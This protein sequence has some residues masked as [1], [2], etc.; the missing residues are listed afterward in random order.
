MISSSSDV[1]KSYGIRAGR[2]VARRVGAGE[3]ARPWELHG[4]FITSPVPFFKSATSGADPLRRHD[5]RPDQSTRTWPRDRSRTG[6]LLITAV[7][8]GEL[9][10]PGVSAANAQADDAGL[11]MWANDGADKVLRDETRTT[12]GSVT[13]SVW[14]GAGVSVFGARNETVSFNL[15]MEATAGDI[16]GVEVS[17]DELTGPG[18]AKITTRAA[19]G[20]EVFDYRGRNIELFY[21]RY[22][23][24]EG[25]STLPYDHYDERHVP[26]RCQRPFELVELGGGVTAGLAVDGTGWQDRPCHDREYPDIAVPL[27]LESPFSVAAGTNQSIWTDIYIPTDSPAGPYT[28][29]VS[30]T[31]ANGRSEVP[32]QLTVRDFSL[33][34][35]RHQSEEEVAEN[36]RSPSSDGTPASHFDDRQLR[37]DR[38]D[39]R[40]LDRPAERQTLYSEARL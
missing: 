28:G 9:V 33:P 39:G 21:V 20:N 35:T 7:V 18:G 14:D 8:A 31:T 36:R 13:N 37:A 32:V 19:A 40:C 29:V 30:V 15:V 3:L 10:G 12:S 25:V 22:L 4:L 26:Q 23:R 17:L 1:T 24:I 2:R 38:R 34:R 16:T 5:E 11:V 6:R 27:E